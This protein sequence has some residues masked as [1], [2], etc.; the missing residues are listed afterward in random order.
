MACSATAGTML[1]AFRAAYRVWPANSGVVIN[2][3]N[4]VLTGAID[5]NALSA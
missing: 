3:H 5:Y 1:L 4:A 2:A